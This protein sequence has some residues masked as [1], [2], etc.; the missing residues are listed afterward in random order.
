MNRPAE[1]KRRSR[2]RHGAEQQRA[3][4]RRHQPI[5]VRDQLQQ[6]EGAERT[7]RELRERR[8]EH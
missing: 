6:P 1:V 4:R 7:H 5:R 2:Q 3:D 8:H